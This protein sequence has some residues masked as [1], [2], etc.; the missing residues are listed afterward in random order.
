MR[1]IFAPVALILALSSP[2]LLH[3]AQAQTP[4]ETAKKPKKK[5]K[6]ARP[7]DAE[8]GKQLYER[9]CVACHGVDGLGDGP[10]AKDLVNGVPTM[11]GVVKKDNIDDYVKPVLYGKG[12]MPGFELSFDEFG[13]RSVLRTMVKRIESNAEKLPKA[14]KPTVDEPSIQVTAPALPSR[15]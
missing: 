5:K 14:S 1:R 15:D 13:A 4:T 2:M 3:I 8:R 9:H 12:R 11:V 6:N 10:M 7:T